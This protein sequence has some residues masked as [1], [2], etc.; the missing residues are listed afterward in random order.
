[1]NL[2]ILLAVSIVLNIELVAAVAFLLKQSSV[3]PDTTLPIV[4]YQPRHPNTGPV[5][6]DRSTGAA[7]PINP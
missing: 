5:A 3:T 1:M 2:K 7:P 4:M 6:G